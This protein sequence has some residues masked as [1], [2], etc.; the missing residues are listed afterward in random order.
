MQNLTW[1]KTE[2]QRWAN[3]PS[4]LGARVTAVYTGEDGTPRVDVVL[5]RSGIPWNLLHVQ[6]PF[7]SVG[8]VGFVIFVDSRRDTPVYVGVRSQVQPLQTATVNNSTPTSVD[9]TITQTGAMLVGIPFVGT[10]PTT[11]K[12]G[13]VG[14][15]DG[16]S[17]SP[18]F[19]G[20]LSS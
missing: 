3:Y 13:V 11:G 8:D 16:L 9:V 14:Y 20:V 7:P 6:T 18:V 10:Q 1:S 2:R 12:T 5:T 15:L 4:G 19:L 17:A